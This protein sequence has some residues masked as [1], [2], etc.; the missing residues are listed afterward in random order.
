MKTHDQDYTGKV[1]RNITGT[2]E[3][4]LNRVQWN[5]RGDP[6]S[7]VPLAPAAAVVAAVAAAVVAVVVAAAFG[8]LFNLGLPLEAGTYNV[9]LSVNGKDYTT[10]VVIENDPGIN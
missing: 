2:K 1:V 3:V 8:G 6:T 7:D 9:K 5:M 4:G 10:K